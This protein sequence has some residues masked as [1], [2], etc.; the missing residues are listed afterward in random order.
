M[1]DEHPVSWLIKNLKP[2]LYA[3][4]AAWIDEVLGDTALKPSEV[5]MPDTR[6]IVFGAYGNFGGE[7]DFKTITKDET[8]KFS[9]GDFAGLQLQACG[10]Y[11]WVPSDGLPVLHDW[12]ST[13]QSIWAGYEG[14]REGLEFKPVKAGLK[15]N[16]LDFG[17]VEVTKGFGRLS[18]LLFTVTYN[19]IHLKNR[20][21][22][23][24]SE[25]F[26]R[27]LGSLGG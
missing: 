27:C 11:H 22:D 3:P 12:A 13:A 26:K 8:S 24:E 10:L 20:L 15:G 5:D 4:L 6:L 25:Q 2:K 9:K 23:E 14:W 21:S 19:Y 7:C 16:Q 1:K 18:I 17:Q